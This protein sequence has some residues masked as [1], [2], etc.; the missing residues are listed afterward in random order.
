MNKSSANN[1]NPQAR[2]KPPYKTLSRTEK[3]NRYKM[4][5]NIATRI[6]NQWQCLYET[7]CMFVYKLSPQEAGICKYPQFGG[8]L[9][10]K[11]EEVDSH[12]KAEVALI[13]L[14]VRI[15][16]KTENSR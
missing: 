11:I 5:E 16:L 14:Q 9:M 4:M 15:K 1:V 10:R 6:V 2:K 7:G 3:R 12:Y 8:I 13:D